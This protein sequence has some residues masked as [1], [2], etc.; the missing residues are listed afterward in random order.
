MGAVVTGS[1]RITVVHGYFL[2]DSGSGTHVREL[3]RELVREGHDVTLVCQERRPELC[4]FIDSVYVLDAANV[5][6][7]PLGEARPPRYAGRCRLVRPNLGGRLLVYVEGPFPGFSREGVKAFQDAPT[8]WIEGY[9][10]ANLEAL[11][12]VFAAWPPDVV[13]ANHA[14][15]QPHVVKH[16]LAGTAPAGAARYVVT[17]HG[18]ELNFSVKQDPRLVSYT[19]DGLDDAAAIITISSTSAQDVVHW[20]HAH[21]LDIAEKTWVVQ[22]GINAETFKP[23]TSRA[24]AVAAVHRE[25]ALPPGFELRRDDDVLAFAGRLMW[26]KGIQHAVAALTLI[27]QRRP[28]VRLLVAGDGPARAPLERLVAH[29]SE[30]DGAGARGLALAEQELRTLPEF[31]PVVPEPPGH[32]GKLHVAFLGHLTP[33]QLARVFAAADVSL[34]PSIFPEALGLVTME[35]LSAGA[36]PIASYH[37]GLM[38]VLDV[39]ADSLADPAFRTLAPGGSLTAELAHVVVD[40]LERYPTADPAFRARLHDLSAQH[41]LSWEKVA[42]R[43]LEL[44]TGAERRETSARSIPSSTLTRPDSITA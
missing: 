2:H 26:T 38:S 27:A 36:L 18:S 17:V 12:T 33:A 35:A 16:A 29:L 43:Y 41:F 5:S 31:G 24:A 8:D 21:G 44:A 3:T 9:V 1:A 20:A 7:A 19:T 40:V 11:R 15:M 32:T 22:P 14:M 42:R 23:A 34:A 28:S 37:S 25:V 4:D 30:G 39:V 13:L 6:A 10:A